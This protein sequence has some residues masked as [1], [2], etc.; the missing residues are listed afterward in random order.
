LFFPLIVRAERAASVSAAAARGNAGPRPQ[1]AGEI[2][3][4]VMSSFAA[5]LAAG[6]RPPTPLAKAIM[7][8]LVLKLLAITAAGIFLSSRNQRPTVD[9]TAISKLIGP[10]PSPHER[11]R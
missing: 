5:F 4:A 11:R 3:N 7:L 10:S 2:L 9:S 6:V 8:V 1:S